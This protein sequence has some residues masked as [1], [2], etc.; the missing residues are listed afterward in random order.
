MRLDKFLSE[1]YPEHSRATWQKFIRE[2]YVFVNKNKI[3]SPTKNVTTD[4]VLTFNIPEPQDFSAQSLPIIYEN[5]NVLVLDK[6]IGVL[7]HSKGA[8]NDEFT[9]AD[10]VANQTSA[11]N[12]TA[13][14]QNNRMGIV[15]R[16]D[17]ATS[18]VIITAKNPETE[19]FLKKQF[20]NKKV[21]KT[22]FAIL[23]RIPKKSEAIINA[24]IARNPKAP[25]T[26]RVD[27]NGKSA[28]TH[29]KVISSNEKGRALVELKPETGRTHQLRVHM[30][31]IGT[32]I[33]GDPLYGREQADRLYLHATE[34]EITVPEAQQ[35]I[36]DGNIN[37]VN[38]RKT[39][40]APIP[41][42]FLEDF[43]DVYN[44]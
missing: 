14:E 27:P 9:V 29:Y 19:T 5:N 33:L 25:A 43:P 39:F 20:Q 1:K 26:F 44:Q 41:K 42:D 12:S 24:P 34:L 31:F 13:E 3:V 8:L 37:Y 18:G 17:R 36:D 30:A 10:F 7:T 32:P 6:P 23:E 38:M 4:D 16:L 35:G 21:K 40:T 2:G 22:Y 11:Q 15:H 28:V